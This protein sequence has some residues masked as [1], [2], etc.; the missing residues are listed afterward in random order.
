MLLDLISRDTEP[1]VGKP[2][3]DGLLEA[4]ADSLSVSSEG[5]DSLDKERK[6]AKSP[7]TGVLLSV[8]ESSSSI[9]SGELNSNLHEHG[10]EADDEVLL[11]L[12]VIA[13]PEPSSTSFARV[14]ERS[15]VPVFRS[16]SRRDVM[17]KKAAADGDSARASCGMPGSSVDF[18]SRTCD[19]LCVR[20]GFVRVGMMTGFEGAA[21]EMDVIV[22]G[23]VL[24]F[25]LENVLVPAG[26]VPTRSA[27]F[28][29]PTRVFR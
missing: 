27:A 26:R 11:V 9:S 29:L 10:L 14:F 15:P 18:A 24:G 5:I 13:S 21:G 17:A 6:D 3:V 4:Y 22:G 16:D 23:P 20:S 28:E 12:S 25:R 19:L 1:R 7:W 8:F 2:G